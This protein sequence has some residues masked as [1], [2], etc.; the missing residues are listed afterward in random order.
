MGKGSLPTT[1]HQGLLT[2][3]DT[4]MDVIINSVVIYILENGLLTWYVLH[5]IVRS[6]R[7]AD[8]HSAATVAA[9]VCVS[10]ED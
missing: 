5:C 6:T 9:L 1:N 10:A 2:T 8:I 3:W 4:R 7:D